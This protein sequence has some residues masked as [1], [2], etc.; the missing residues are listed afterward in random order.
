M[1]VVSDFTAI[2]SGSYLN[3]AARQGA[4]YT[5]SFLTS[6]PAHY[7][8]RYSP[9]ALA[10][11]R[12]FTEEERQ[13]ARQALEAWASISGLTFFE[14]PGDQGDMAFGSYD[15][16]LM[17]YGS[18]LGYA[19][20]PR[21]RLDDPIRSDIFFERDGSPY[22]QLMLHEVGHALG[23]K[24]SH[25]GD[26]TLNFQ[27]DNYSYT[28]MSY[29]SG[30][31]SGE[32]P[33]TFDVEAIQYLYGGPGA[34]GTQ[35]TSWSWD[36][37]SYTLSQTGGAAVDAIFGVGTADVIA[38]LGGND[39]IQGRGGGDQ[40]NGGDG[41]DEI[42]GGGGNDVL[43][44]ET[45]A[46][47]LEGGEGDDRLAGGAGADILI[48]GLGDDRIEGGGD[49]DTL[50]GNAG[51]DRFVYS[52]AGDSTAAARDWLR[53]FETGVDK[54]DLGALAPTNVSWTESPSPN[55]PGVDS[56]VTVT[57]AGGTLTLLVEGQVSQ[58][59]FILSFTPPGPIVGSPGNDVL[60]GTGGADTIQGEGGDDILNGQDG[61][62]SLVGG[63]GADR[64]IGGAG[65]DTYW[66]DDAG[67]VIE[68][69]AEAGT[70]LA[71]SSVSYLLAANVEDLTLTGT[72]DIDATGNGLANLL[73]G[74]SG[75]N[76]LDGGA[77]ADQLAGGPGDDIYVVDAG[78]TVHEAGG[79]GI[80]AVRTALA[81]YALGADVEN[82]LGLSA[83]GQSLTGNG[84]ANAITGG[85]GGDFIDGG[86]GA[87]LLAGGSGNDIYVV[88][89]GDVVIEDAAAGTDEIRTALAAYTL[90]ANVEGL[91]GLS[92]S[93]QALTGNGSANN[94]VGGIGNDVID[95]GGGADVL[96]GGLGNDIYI[97]DSGDTVAEAAGA[98]TDEVRTGLAAHA[99]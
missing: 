34:D 6:V 33:G 55:Y 64:M 85:A 52:S 17:G 81:A 39:F 10:T 94:I 79:S 71:I 47:R 82:L 44:G 28:V 13:T 48:A 18:F 59:D 1:T 30:G 51:A 19:F 5:Y 31:F 77:G 93:G 84:L 67:D 36:P 97:V 57:T 45:G 89:S 37:A 54:I 60:Q 25:E 65:H 29:K 83:A 69:G 62:D 90:G 86:A 78:D 35:V 74:N 12:P 96:A 99:L 56:L 2:L 22:L 50:Y 92:A 16:T 76:L 42:L 41:D 80:D 66:I 70:D 21:G 23:L 73:H 4:F 9:A 98:G 88:D 58:S 27:Y 68:E 38:G 46:D 20:Y 32:T 43:T 7:A 15:M 87:D 72:A 53:S 61:N 75:S 3:D 40:L 24:H 95:G 63:A 11:F 49:G 14:V 8:S 26:P 91:A